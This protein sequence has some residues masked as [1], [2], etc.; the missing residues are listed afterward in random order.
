MVGLGGK[1]IPMSKQQEETKKF[2]EKEKQ[3]KNHS[4]TLHLL[5][6]YDK[7]LAP[8]KASK[9]RDWWDDFSIDD[10]TNNHAKFC[11]P[12]TMAS[13]IGYYILSPA[14]FTVSWDGDIKNDAIVEVYDDAASHAFID[15]H[16]TRGGFT[17]Q[18]MF[19]PRT[20][21]PGDFIY[22]K[23]VPNQYRKPYYVLEGIIEAWWN[24]ARFGVVFMLNRGGRFKINKGEPIAQMILMTSATLNADLTLTTEPA[25][26]QPEFDAKRSRPDYPGKEFDYMKGLLPDGTEV[27]PHFKH[28]HSKVNDE[29]D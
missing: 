9:N 1:V 18:S 11:L 15:N 4:I 21:N 2:V 8:V 25:D 27:C 13:G 19:I 12:M 7:T 22:I 20:E 10:K 23:G 29:T 5:D 26:Q 6:D 3:E 17:V 28:W 16:S 14:T 24:P